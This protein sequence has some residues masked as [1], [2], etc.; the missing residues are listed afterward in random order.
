MRPIFFLVALYAL[1][2]PT[3]SHSSND[4]DF[5]NGAIQFKDENIVNVDNLLFRLRNRHGSVDSESIVVKRSPDSP[6]LQ[7]N[8]SNIKEVFALGDDFCLNQRVQIELKNGKIDEFILARHT[9][10]TYL[11]YDEFAMLEVESR[12]NCDSILRVSFGDSFGNT[13]INSRT[14]KRWPLSYRF[15]PYTGE[16]LD[17]TNSRSD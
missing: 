10:M 1:M 3:L 12:S 9:F 15:D 4:V 2:I 13:R 17:L 16:S 6:E 8:R 5:H 14:N 11:L 7:I